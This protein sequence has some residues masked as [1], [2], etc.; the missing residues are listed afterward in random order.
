M[1]SA[2]GLRIDE[3]LAN[4]KL[5]LFAPSACAHYTPPNEPKAN[6]QRAESVVVAVGDRVLHAL[7]AHVAERLR[8]AGRVLVAWVQ[9][10]KIRG[11]H[12]H[13]A[14]E[15]RS[16]TLYIVPGMKSSMFVVSAPVDLTRTWYGPTGGETS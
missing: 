8:R 3:S 1:R 5:Y 12:G 15:S 11:R 9:C 14:N 6:R 2:R 7:L 13:F 10:C 4:A 16:G